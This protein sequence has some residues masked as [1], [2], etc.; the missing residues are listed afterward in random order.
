[1]TTGGVRTARVVDAS[2]RDVIRPA[3]GLI[4]SALGLVPTAPIPVWTSTKQV[5]RAVEPEVLAPKRVARGLTLHIPTLVPD[6]M[7]ILACA[8]GTQPDT[9]CDGAVCA[10]CTA[11]WPS[12]PPYAIASCVH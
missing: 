4:A 9:S 10:A 1:M 3:R 7:G 12:R 2:A 5:G 6:A 11:V 8:A